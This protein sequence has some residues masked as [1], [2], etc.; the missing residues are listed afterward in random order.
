MM[1]ITTAMFLFIFQITITLNLVIS[2]ITEMEMNVV[3]VE[4][5]TEYTTLP[6]EVQYGVNF[7]LT[8]FSLFSGKRVLFFVTGECV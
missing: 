4:R 5:V 1:K 8:I 3:S 6:S 7:S 2:A